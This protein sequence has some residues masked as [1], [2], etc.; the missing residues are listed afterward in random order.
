[1]PVYA[2]CTRF[3]HISCI[4]IQVLS[5]HLFKFVHQL[6]AFWTLMNFG[7]LYTYAS[8]CVLG[9]PE[10]GLYNFSYFTVCLNKINYVPFWTLTHFCKCMYVF[11]Q[12]MCITVSLYSYEYL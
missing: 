10:Y 9:I 12:H 4:T 11:W 5:L 2:F 7:H 8:V 3:A 1:M 6:C